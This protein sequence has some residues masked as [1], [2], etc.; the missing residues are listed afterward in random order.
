MIHN[1]SNVIDLLDTHVEQTNH[2]VS[3]RLIIIQARFRS[4]Q[5]WKEILNSHG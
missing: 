1:N 3:S 4:C 5:A 2:Q